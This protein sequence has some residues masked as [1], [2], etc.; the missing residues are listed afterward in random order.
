MSLSCPSC[1]LVF[2]IFGASLSVG[3]ALYCSIG[4]RSHGP[5]EIPLLAQRFQQDSMALRAMLYWATE[6]VADCIAG[7]AERRHREERTRCAVEVGK[8]S[9][10][11]TIRDTLRDTAA[12]AIPM[13]IATRAMP[14]R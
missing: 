7:G 3:A 1:C 14:T 12:T 10:G 2:S 4:P 13:A 6:A 5:G 11:T 9:S 8:I